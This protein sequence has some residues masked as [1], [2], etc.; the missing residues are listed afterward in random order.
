MAPATQI[1]VVDDRASVREVLRE[2]LSELGYAVLEASD[3]GE[4][5]MLLKRAPIDLVV[6]DLRMPGVDGMDLLRRIPRDGPPTLLFSAHG[7]VPTAVEAMREGAIDFVTLPLSGEALAERITAHLEPARTQAPPSTSIVGEHPSILAMRERIAK[8]AV[9]EVSVLI[10]GESGVGKELVAREIHRLSPRAGS[11][12][13]ALNCCALHESLLESELF[14]HEKG[15]FTGA[16]SRRIGHFERADG[17][18][19]FLDEIGDAPLATQSKLLRVLQEGEFERVGGLRTI[20]VDVRVVAATNRDLGGMRDRGS[21]REDLFHRLN[22]LP[23]RVPPLRERTS[24]L[25][26]LVRALGARLGVELRWTEAAL[27]R[28][29]AHP[30]PGNVRELENAIQR[31][32]IQSDGECMVVLEHVEQALGEAAVVVP[33]P[34][35]SFEEEERARYEHLLESHR[36]NVSAVARELGLSRGALRHRLRKYGLS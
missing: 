9:R 32:G 26:L 8:V 31:V 35:A 6:T 12:F 15:A 18:T 20:S 36:W 16:T 7:D 14:G 3:G 33:S 11:P 10:T 23:V 29:R 25:P 27:A 28:L 21:F 4:A 22:V 1:L 5:L 17:G 34:R 13:I 30:W 24:D 2:Q 19:L